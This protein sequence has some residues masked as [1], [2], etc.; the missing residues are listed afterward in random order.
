MTP[1]SL[2]VE[3]IGSTIMFIGILYLSYLIQ[4]APSTIH[5]IHHRIQK[6]G[7]IGAILF[8][9]LPELPEFTLL[10]F[11]MAF[12]FLVFHYCYGFSMKS[13]CSDSLLIVPSVLDKHR[14]QL[15]LA[16]LS[17]P[18]T[19]DVYNDL[20]LVLDELRLVGV[21]TVI[22]ESPLFSKREQLRSTLYFNY[23]LKKKGIVLES[24]STPFYTKPWSCLLLAIQKYILLV[25]SIQ[26]LPLTR[27]H[28]YT[29]LLP[30]TPNHDYQNDN[31][32]LGCNK[33]KR[34]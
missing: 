29:L 18:L 15:H 11:V 4:T 8:G 23:M 7:A 14:V 6:T 9:L 27:W 28:Q 13:M 25:P 2:L 10:S 19:R 26:S 5:D 34:R 17:Q 22:L 12:G 3:L 20:F 32:E 30:N 24:K 31:W 33:A 1:F 21:H 16:T